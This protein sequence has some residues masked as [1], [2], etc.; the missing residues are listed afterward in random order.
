[1]GKHAMILLSITGP[2]EGLK[3]RGC[4]DF[5]LGIICPP[6]LF[7]I[8]LTDLPPPAPPGTTGLH[9]YSFLVSKFGLI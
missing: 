2:S 4:Q 6:P 5:L 1:M 7:K 9:Y 3:I 8:G